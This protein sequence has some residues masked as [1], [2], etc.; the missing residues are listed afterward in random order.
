M[1]FL[2]DD[3]RRDPYPVYEQMR[4]ASP[5]ILEPRTGMWMVFDYEGVK[6]A[7]SDQESFSSDLAAAHGHPTP[8]WMIFM[9]PPRHTKLRGLIMRAFTPRMV[10]NLEPQIR[11]LVRSLLDRA[12]DG[13]E[14]DLA[15]DFAVPL[16]IQVIAGMI[17]IPAAD[18][19][20]FLR[21]SDATLKLSLTMIDN[22]EAARATQGYF[23]ATMEMSEWLP[24]IVEQRRSAPAG[25]LLSALIQ[26]EV[27]GQ[28]L[29]HDEL[30]GFVQLLIVAGN[31]TTVNLI[32]N[33]ALCFMEHP[34]A[35]ARVRAAP[36]LLPS[37]IEEVL[38]YRAP[39]QWMYRGTRRE[40][41][42]HGQTIPARS[43]VLAVIGSA[44]R[45]PRQFADPARFDIT[46]DPNPHIAFGHGIHFCIGAPLARL[47]ARIALEELLR[48]MKTFERASSE[49][50]TPRQALNVHGPASLRIRFSA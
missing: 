17:G 3:I 45:D 23:A 25:D 18:W 49:P 11:E 2:S 9:D 42:M 6:R 33:A 35:L 5:L 13:R 22:E 24:Q 43:M 30:L 10:S 37:A 36:D 26:A 50:W 27:D 1:N 4:R 15:A 46:R 19:E 20:R 41:E 44:N 31:E 21:W 47:E 39:L 48:R 12:M 16:P 34:E 38:R 7:L 14:M 28:R 40:V 32:N 8:K 29:T